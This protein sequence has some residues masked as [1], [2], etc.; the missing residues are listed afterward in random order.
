M[1][2]LSKVIM[3]EVLC[4]IADQYLFEQAGCFEWMLEDDVA[5]RITYYSGFI[6]RAV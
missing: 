3:E 4:K 2:R 1:Y 5:S 6:V